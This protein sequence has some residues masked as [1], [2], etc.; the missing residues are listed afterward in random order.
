MNKRSRTPSTCTHRGIQESRDAR[1]TVAIPSVKSVKTRELLQ[2]KSWQ[3]ATSIVLLLL[4][5]PCHYCQAD[6]SSAQVDGKNPHNFSKVQQQFLP[7]RSAPRSFILASSS[8][9]QY[10]YPYRSTAATKRPKEDYAITYKFPDEEEAET[11]KQKQLE[12]EN[13]RLEKETQRLEK[14]QQLQEKKQRQEQQRQD[15]EQQ[16][17]VEQR[18]RQAKMQQDTKTTKQATKTKQTQTKQPLVDDFGFDLSQPPSRKQILQQEQKEAT[19]DAARQESK[20]LEEGKSAAIA[21]DATTGMAWNTAKAIASGVGVCASVVA[22]SSSNNNDNNNKLK[23]NSKSNSKSKTSNKNNKNKNKPKG[24]GW[25]R[26]NNNNNNKRQQSTTQRTLLPIKPRWPFQPHATKPSRR[27][28]TPADDHPL[29]LQSEA[30]IRNH[31]ILQWLFGREKL[32]WTLSAIVAL[33]YLVALTS[34]IGCDYYHDHRHPICW[35]PLRDMTAS[36]HDGFCVWGANPTTGACTSNIHNSHQ[37]SFYVDT[38]LAVLTLLVG[39]ANRTGTSW[40]VGIALL[41]G[42]HGL[43][44]LGI[45]HGVVCEGSLE[46]CWL[47]CPGTADAMAAPWQWILYGLYNLGVVT[48]DVRMAHFRLPL[49]L[50]YVLIGVVTVAFCALGSFA[51]ATW[52][53]PAVFVQS[54]ALV[55][56]TGVF[57]NCDRITPFMGWWFL[58]ATVVGLTEFLACEPVLLKV[59]Y[60]HVAYDTVLHL[61]M[62]ASLVPRQY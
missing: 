24:I 23:N 43:L 25:T 2:C 33:V 59:G 21:T 39:H 34:R 37:Y 57:A 60:G 20:Q 46:H 42:L 44:H 5:V 40:M 9:Y 51:G 35:A 41:I 50:Q 8:N 53:L 56:V 3:S 61:A 7:R 16:K 13:K 19:E 27:W 6:H 15:R 10:Q 1:S 29:A 48:M 52:A 55:S 58:G 49:V 31:G 62:M 12:K 36:L 4:S 32:P 22:S 14:K 18:Q 11:Q 26:A 28:T 47:S 38:A 54:H 30:T 17:L 45:S